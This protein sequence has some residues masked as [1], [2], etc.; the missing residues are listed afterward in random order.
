M[1]SEFR[2]EEVWLFGWSLRGAKAPCLTL[3][4]TQTDL[5]TVITFLPSFKLGTSPF[6]LPEIREKSRLFLKI[7][8][9]F[10]G[11]FCM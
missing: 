8:T 11:E 10:V 1:L 7:G 6:L 4:S 3:W 2:L 5:R 9:F